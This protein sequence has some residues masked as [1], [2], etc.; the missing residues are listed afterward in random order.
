MQIPGT[1][2]SARNGK[3]EEKNNEKEA[4]DVGKDV[5]ADINEY[6]AKLDQDEDDDEEAIKNLEVLTFEVSSF[7]SV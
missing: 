1:A 5:P 6:Y 4:S 3:G 7:C 2:T